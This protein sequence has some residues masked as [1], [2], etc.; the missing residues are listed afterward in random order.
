MRFERAR[1]S[2][3]RDCARRQTREERQLLPREEAQLQPAEDVVHQRLGITDLLVASPARRLKAC[4]RKL[5]AEHLE[6][7]TM[8]QR[9][10][11]GGGKGIHQSGDGGS[12]LAHLD[13]Y[14]AGL[15]VGIQ[16]DRDVAFMSGNGE[17]VRE[18]SP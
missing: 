10:G 16:A 5:L 17:L 15:P 3:S 9:D 12:F 11:D 7:N 18:R 1:L 14:L 2:A 4:V 13:E 8:L 6:G